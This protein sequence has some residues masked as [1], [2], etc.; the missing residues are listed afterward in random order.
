MI[1]EFYKAK[2][3]VVD[4]AVL[5]DNGQYKEDMITVFD[6]KTIHDAIERAVRR[7]SK[8]FDIDPTVKKWGIWNVGARAELNEQLLS[9]DDD[10]EDDEDVF[11]TLVDMKED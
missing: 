4:Y 5:Y 1:A 11:T 8:K 3:W 2:D 6:E 10:D 9:M 7:L